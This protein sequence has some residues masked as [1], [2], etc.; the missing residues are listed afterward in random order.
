[1]SGEALR[2]MQEPLVRGAGSECAG[3]GW[4]VRDVV[5]HRVLSHGG[6][7]NG[8][9]GLLTLVPD[10]GMAIVSLAN[11]RLARSANDAIAAWAFRRYVG[12]A[13]AEPVP[14]ELDDPRL[15]ALVVRDVLPDKAIV[16]ARRNNRLGITYKP[17]VGPQSTGPGLP[18]QPAALTT[19]GRMVILEGPFEGVTGD[20][21][22]EPDASIAWVRLGG[23]IYPREAPVTSTERRWDPGSGPDLR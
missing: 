2:S 19:D 13:D 1:L 4:V 7:W 16:I 12:A 5:S 18:E 8:Q 20:F 22:I 10:R 6:D 11:S 21:S 23:R 15:D 17:T 9:Q 14:V 3:I